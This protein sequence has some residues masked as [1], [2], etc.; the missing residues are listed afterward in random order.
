[1]GAQEEL[2]GGEGRGKWY[3]Y[4]MH[5]LNSEKIYKILKIELNEVLLV[6]ILLNIQE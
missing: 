6:T 1:M 5:I 3:K 2:E 4:N